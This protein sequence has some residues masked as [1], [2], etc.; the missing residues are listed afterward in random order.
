[1][2]QW[3]TLTASQVFLSHRQA[4]LPPRCLLRLEKLSNQWQARK[5]QPLCFHH[6][7]NEHNHAAAFDA[8]CMPKVL[9]HI[10]LSFRPTL[11]NITSSPKPQPKRVWKVNAPL[12]HKTGV[13]PCRAD[14]DA[15]AGKGVPA[16]RQREG[17]RR[18]ALS[19]K[20]RQ[21]ADLRTRT[22]VAGWPRACARD[23]NLQ[24][25]DGI[26]TAPGASRL[27]PGPPMRRTRPFQWLKVFPV[28]TGKSAYVQEIA[29]AK[30]RNQRCNVR[31][32]SS[33]KGGRMN[34]ATPQGEARPRVPS[35]RLRLTH[36][37]GSL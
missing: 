34:G 26:R 33:W 4:K 23:R 18:P 37:W 8:H 11:G 17:L 29:S 12:L 35:T 1:M 30:D 28:Q 31:A 24:G 13:K 16:R 22:S 25:G 27:E 19:S 20:I 3:L 2:L 9:A 36:Y 14:F 15:V 10:P 21:Q 5:S 6:S 32:G 7:R